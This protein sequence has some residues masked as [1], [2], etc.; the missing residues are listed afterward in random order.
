M[1]AGADGGG[2][3]GAARTPPRK[4]RRTAA[5]VKAELEGKRNK[6]MGKRGRPRREEVRAMADG[7]AEEARGTAA[8]VAE[9]DGE[10]EAA[11]RIRG[12]LAVDTQT[13]YALDEADCAVAKKQGKPLRPRVLV[14]TASHERADAVAAAMPT[15]PFRLVPSK[16]TKKADA[17][18]DELLAAQA[19]KSDAN[20]NAGL[21]VA[22]AHRALALVERGAVHLGHTTALVVDTAPDAKGRRLLDMADVTPALWGL[23][24]QV[25]DSARLVFAAG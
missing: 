25:P 9:A 3:D 11:A 7:G 5:D 23:L 10:H 14:V 17:H 1:V 21:A 15:P 6:A 2:E 22:T 19:T 16:H 20:R 18:G 8:A 12:V 13:S 24:A 4:A